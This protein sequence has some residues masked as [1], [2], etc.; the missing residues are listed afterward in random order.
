MTPPDDEAVSLIKEKAPNKA[1]VERIAELEIDLEDVFPEMGSLLSSYDVPSSS[2]ASVIVAIDTN[3]LLLPYNISKDDLS[4]LGAI[5]RKLSEE[6]RLYIPARCIR[7]FIKHRDRK[8]G[9]LIHGLNNKLSRIGVVED[10]LSP[11]L[12]DVEGY[13][14]L[15]K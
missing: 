9:E 7:E 4:A 3:A 6:K 10:T 2:N 8:L 1:T 5:Y 14:D 13:K 15:E 11:L 12:K